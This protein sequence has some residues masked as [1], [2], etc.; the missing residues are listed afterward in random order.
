MSVKNK[1][2]KIANAAAGAQAKPVPSHA[3]AKV[4]EVPCKPLPPKDSTA[5]YLSLDASRAITAA[6]STVLG[7]DESALSDSDDNKSAKP[8]RS[9]YDTDPSWTCLPSYPTVDIHSFFDH[10][11]GY[12]TIPIMWIW[13]ILFVSAQRL[14]TS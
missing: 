4:P 13:L 9:N 2:K 12:L 10:Q 7:F 14:F 3:A 1:A 8:K 5:K 6:R 11:V